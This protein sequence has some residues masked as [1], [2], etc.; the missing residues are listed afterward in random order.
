MK[1]R[2]PM[3]VILM[4]MV[5][6]FGCSLKLGK[7]PAS[8]TYYVLRDPG[9]GEKTYREKPLSLLLGEATAPAL[10]SSR[11]IVFSRTPD[12]RSFYQYAS[13]TETPPRMFTRLLLGRLEKARLFNSVCRRPAVVHTDLQLSV[14]LIEFYHDAGSRP[15]TANIKIRAQLFDNRKKT[16]IDQRYFSHR[17]AVPTYDASG[18]VRGFSRAVG[19]VLDDV[20]AWLDEVTED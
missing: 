4:V 14:T 18:A 9:G 15:G 10:V 11:K 7:K 13:W 3:V 16:T 19:L 8:K 2:L 20:I 1:Y 5:S 12:T 6:G 17:A